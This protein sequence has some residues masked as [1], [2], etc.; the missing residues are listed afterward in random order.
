MKFVG[1][2]WLK[3]L[4]LVKY[5]YI[6]IGEILV[7]SDSDSGIANWFLAFLREIYEFGDI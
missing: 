4:G 7:K 2:M 1:L 6:Y 5:I 3:Y